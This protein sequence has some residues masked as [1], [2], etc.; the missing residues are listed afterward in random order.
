[1]WKTIRSAR[2]K[3]EEGCMI[4]RNHHRNSTLLIDRRDL[5]K[6][7][8]L[9]VTS[10]ALPGYMSGRG[11][12]AGEPS[13][14]KPN[15]IFIMADDLGYGDLSCYGATKVKTPNINRMAKEGVRFTDA[16]S[17]S[18]VCSPTRY[19]VLTGRYCWRTRLK[20]WVCP[21]NDPLLIEKDR[22]T[23]A[24]LLKS[25][26][27]TTGC[28]GKWHLGFG[29]ERPDWNRQLKPGP[30]EVGFDYYFGVPTSHNWAPYVYVENHHVV[31]RRENEFI[32]VDD[33]GT[34]KQGIAAK[35]NSE[36][37]ALIQTGKVIEFIQCN[38]DKP[39][40]LYFA[41]CNVHK[42]YTPNDRF[43]GTSQCGIYGDFTHEFD[44]TVGEVLNTLDRLRLYDKTLIIVTSDNGA[45]DEFRKFGHSSCGFLR[46][47]KTDIWEGGH[48]VPFVA[49]WPGKIKA[50]TTSDEVI[51]LTD[52]MATSAAV[53]GAELPNNAGEDSYNILPILLGQKAD[54]RIRE[55][56]VHHSI[57]GVFSIRQGPWKLILGRGSGGWSKPHYVKPKPGEP[58][59][60][61][62]NL[63][64]D[65]TET[66][67][68][69]SRHPEIVKRLAK[70]LEKY[71]KESHSRPLKGC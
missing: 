55:A 62:Y 64:K 29:E 32:E 2:K 25:A 56:T 54:R 57:S 53:V 36:E 46:G 19:G 39:F 31:G 8:G 43:K 17:P 9:G 33:N 16:H 30:L 22:L 61:L 40:F 45:N 42:P 50:G 44:W 20:Q 11:C 27:Y 18:A 4:E 58:E 66:D 49:R 65:P 47:Q 13:T 3:Q 69:W 52:F 23:V 35:R 21:P 6:A 38:K 34:E 60:Q 12:F 51:C 71:K 67:N 68:V 37:I 48:R 1:M 7:L 70:L 28:V 63:K 41:T 24:S 14:D 5:L 15:I 26:G 59:G 10:I